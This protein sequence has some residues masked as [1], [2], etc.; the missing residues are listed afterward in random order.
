MIIRTNVKVKIS[1]LSSP[2]KI[3]NALQ[4]SR[5]NV[6][7]TQLR[8]IYCGKFHRMTNL[9][10]KV[11]LRWWIAAQKFNKRAGKKASTGII[12]KIYTY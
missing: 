9:V 3:K 6:K 12:E 1:Q 7:S 8:C 10:Q 2:L 11:I 5:L 4:Q